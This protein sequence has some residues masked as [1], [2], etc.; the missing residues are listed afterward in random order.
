[1]SGFYAVNQINIKDAKKLIETVASIHPF[2]YMKLLA[3]D[4]KIL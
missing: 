2:F 1:M 4:A 3:K